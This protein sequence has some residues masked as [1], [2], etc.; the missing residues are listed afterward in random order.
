[1]G[2]GRGTS[3]RA[4]QT[5][6]GRTQ[7]PDCVEAQG[8]LVFAAWPGAPSGCAP[9]PTVWSTLL[10]SFLHCVAEASR[11]LTPHARAAAPCRSLDGLE[12]GCELPHW[13]Q[14]QVKA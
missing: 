1:M 5:P 6:P 4:L 12:P 13:V 3:T 8:L 11:Q 9:R 7:V 14:T 2:G 10:V